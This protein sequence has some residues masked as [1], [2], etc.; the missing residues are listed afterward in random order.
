KSNRRPAYVAVGEFRPAAEQP[1]WFSESRLLMDN[2]GHGIGPLNR[3]DIGGYTSFTTR[4]GKNVLW[5]P[6]RK[7]FL[8]GKTI[9]TGILDG[10]TAP[11]A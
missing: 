1:I 8:L 6:E 10:L 7:F 2:G 5:H 4:G 3:V 9:T 11:R